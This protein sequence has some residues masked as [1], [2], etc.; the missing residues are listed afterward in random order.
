MASKALPSP[1]VLRQLLRYEP[2]TGK[3]FWRERSVIWFQ[4]TPLRK[5]THACSIWNARYAGKEAFTAHSYGYRCGRIFDRL[6][7]AHRV[8]FALMMGRWPE[9]ELDH[10]DLNRSNNRWGNIR[11]A[12]GME[13]RRN[14]AVRRDSKLGI[15]GVQERENGRFA[16]RIK[17]GGQDIRLGRFGCATAARIA[18]A[19]ASAELHGAFGR[20]E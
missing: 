7:P 17:V 9:E 12:S 20:A 14:K 1:E 5:A 18:Y 16:A 11:P 10:A 15:K 8:I 4:D 19:R 3:L 2:E 6:H 13:N